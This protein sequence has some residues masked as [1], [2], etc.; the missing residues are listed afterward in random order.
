MS[1]QLVSSLTAPAF[2]STTLVSVSKHSG[3]RPVDRPDGST[4]PNIQ[5]TLL[6]DAAFVQRV[7]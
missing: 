6:E 4:N 1:A 5:V 3:D 2:P 7:R